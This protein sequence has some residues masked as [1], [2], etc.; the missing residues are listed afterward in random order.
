MVYLRLFSPAIV[1]AIWAIV[2]MLGAR[3]DLLVGVGLALV[4]VA[5]FSSAHESL[6][7]WHRDH[8]R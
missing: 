5:S 4:S 7:R 8:P 2:W 6:R 3:S 1:L